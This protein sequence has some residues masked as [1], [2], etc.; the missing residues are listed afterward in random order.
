MD[1]II[2]GQRIDGGLDDARVAAR[3]RARLRH[4]SS[5]AVHAHREIESAERVAEDFVDEGWCSVRLGLFEMTEGCGEEIEAELSVKDFVAEEEIDARVRDVQVRGFADGGVARGADAFGDAERGDDLADEA[6]LRGLG[7]EGTEDFGGDVIGAAQRCEDFG[8]E[9]CVDLFVFEETFE[10]GDDRR[11]EREGA[12]GRD[13]T[14]RD[15]AG[16]G[17]VVDTSR[18]DEKSGGMGWRRDR[19]ECREIF[20]ADHVGSIDASSIGES[21]EVAEIA[22]ARELT[23]FRRSSSSRLRLRSLPHRERHRRCHR[24][25]RDIG[26][27]CSGNRD[28][29]V[30]DSIRSIPVRSA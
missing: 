20:V 8:R 22:H 7:G 3:L 23:R 15:F 12:R 24:G 13:E 9:R 26:R 25:T 19:R 10:R 18:P 28:G 14:A 21:I 11:V 6:S 30:A 16:A 17:F 27:T 29:P 4:A 2:E 1:R 5:F